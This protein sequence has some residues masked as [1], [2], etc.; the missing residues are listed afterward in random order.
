MKSLTYNLQDTDQSSAHFYHDLDK[1]AGQVVAYPDRLLHQIAASMKLRSNQ[2]TGSQSRTEKEYFFELL[3]LGVLWNNYRSAA[4]PAGEFQLQLLKQLYKIRKR[5]LWLKPSVDLLRGKLMASLKLK[6]SH[7]PALLNMKSH[8]RLLLFLEAC[9]DYWEEARRLRE[10]LPLLEKLPNET[11]VWQHI[12]Q[13]SE[14]FQQQAAASLGSYTTNVSHFIERNAPFYTHREDRLL[15]LRA[16]SEYHLNMVGAQIMNDALSSS[17]RD[18]QK[19]VVLLPT[20]MRSV[21]EANCKALSDDLVRECIGC[22]A[23]C[24]V[25]CV[26]RSL[27]NPLHTVFLIP[28]SSN[29][30]R[31]LRKWQ[32][33]KDTALIGVAC[34]P[35]LIM[36]GYEMQSLG[37][38]SQCV[39]LDYCGCQKHWSPIH[40]IATNLDLNRLHI[41]LNQ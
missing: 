6:E 10:W 16:E 34:V 40:P 21:P 27:N 13:L 26:K 14:W 7:A 30:S 9:G 20:C 29:F 3:M 28:H 19:K 36:G 8:G 24:N 25:G 17:F 23:D 39:F 1:F 2:Q 15:C 35:N 5:Y 22:N 11:E 33:Q 41:I 37:I 32:G 38:S 4:L 18:T 12:E 31:F